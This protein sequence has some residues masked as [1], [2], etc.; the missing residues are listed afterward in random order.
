MCVRHLRLELPSA[1]SGNQNL[2]ML[3]MPYLTQVGGSGKRGFGLG[4]AGWFME[5]EISYSG[6]NPFN[7]CSVATMPAQ[8]GSFEFYVR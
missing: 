7:S 8:L 4:N 3:V 1:P 5:S 2:K 6:G